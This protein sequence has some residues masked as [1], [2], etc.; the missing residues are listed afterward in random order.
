ML[1]AE[2]RQQQDLPVVTRT[3]LLFCSFCKA[4]NQQV[5]EAAAYHI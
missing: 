4:M 2:F 5:H 3:L 1:G